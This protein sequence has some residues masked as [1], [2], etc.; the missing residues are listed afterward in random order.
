[1][2]FIDYY[3]TNY[4]SLTENKHAMVNSQIVLDSDQQ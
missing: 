3:K 4:S 2:C 1:M